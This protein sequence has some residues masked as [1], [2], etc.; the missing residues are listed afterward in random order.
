M[1]K[2]KKRKDLVK[3]L[4]ARMLASYLT[5]TLG[6]LLLTGVTVGALL[7]VTVLG[8]K[9]EEM[10]RELA[11][12]NLAEMN[13]FAR[14]FLRLEDYCLTFIG[15]RGEDGEYLRLWKELGGAQ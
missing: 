3:S 6:A 12:I 1:R 9:K 14:D 15:P 8:E 4:Y 13:R 7:R 5:V 2:K 10:V 11:V